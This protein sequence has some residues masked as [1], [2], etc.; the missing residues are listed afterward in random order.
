MT[1]TMDELTAP[2][3]TEMDWN[4]RRPMALTSDETDS[5]A[6][7]DICENRGAKAPAVDQTLPQLLY[8]LAV[9]L[10][11][12]PDIQAVCVWL[13]EPVRQIIRLHVLMADFPANVTA[14]KDFPVDDAIAEWVWEHQQRVIINAAAE[15]RFPEFAQALLQTGI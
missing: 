10:P 15:K 1:T 8:E 9:R 3:V 2:S 14:S 12:Q 11:V 7:G 4:Q 5:A 6:S 13:Y